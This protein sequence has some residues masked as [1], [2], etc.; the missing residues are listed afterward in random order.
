MLEAFK[1]FVEEQRTENAED[2]QGNDEL[3]VELYPVASGL[4]FTSWLA[5]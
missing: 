2:R 4:N 1:G 5:V 3:G